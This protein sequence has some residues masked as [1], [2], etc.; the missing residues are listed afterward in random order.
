MD[1]HEPRNILDRAGTIHHCVSVGQPDNGRYP[2]SESGAMRKIF[3]IFM[4]LLLWPLLGRA[5]T[6]TEISSSFPSGT[7][8][9]GTYT[10]ANAVPSQMIGQQPVWYNALDQKMMAFWPD[11]IC[12]NCEW[13]N[14]L[15]EY[16]PATNTFSLAWDGLNWQVNGNGAAALNCSGCSISRTSGVSTVVLSSAEA[17]NLAVGDSFLI[18]GISDST[19]NGQ[20]QVASV[21]GCNSLGNLCTTFTYTQTGQPDSSPGA[22]SGSALAICPA[23]R[24]A[25][26]ERRHSQGMVYD[27]TRNAIWMMTGVGDV[28]ANAT[29]ILFAHSGFEDLYKATYNSP[30]SGHWGW[31]QICGF[32]SSDCGVVNGGVAG[33][34]IPCDPSNSSG[35]GYKFPLIAYDPTNDVIVLFGGNWNSST[36]NETLLYYP[37][38]N[39]WQ[40][41]CPS[42]TSNICN[43][44]TPP[45]RWA[46]GDS[47]MPAIGNGNILLFGHDSGGG[48]NYSDTWIF[49]TTSKTWT[50]V[51]S[52]LVPPATLNPIMDYD[53]VINKVILIDDA[54]SPAHTWF[55]DPTT[56]Q[57][58]DAGYT[59]GPTISTSPGYQSTGAYDA[60][61]N[62]FVVFNGSSGNPTQ[63]WA[64]SLPTSL[65]G[66]SPTADLSP[67]SLTFST[68]TIG[69]TSSSQTVTLT[70]SGTAALT[71]SSISI[72]GSNS[73][74]FA[75]S[76]NCPVS[77]STLSVGASCTISVT[78]TPTLTTTE[79][80][81]LNVSDN[82]AGT[83][84]SLPLTGTG[85]TSTSGGG[86][87]GGSG[88][89]QAV[90][91]PI[92]V[93]AATWNGAPTAS[94]A[95]SNAPVTLG[96]P[97]PDSA[98]VTCSPT[99][100]PLG[101][102]STTAQLELQNGS[103]T[104]QNAQFRCLGLWPDGNAEWVLV[105]GQ[106]P[107][108]TDGTEDTSLNLVQ[109]G[110]GG[111]NNP[112]TSMAVQC[113]GSGTPVSGC[114]DSNHIL[115][116]TTAATFLVKEA[117][118]NLFDSVVVGSTTLVSSG[119]HG[120][121]D[122]LIL[123]GPV[124]PTAGGPARTGID[125]ASCNPGPPPT[126]YSGTSACS[127]GTAGSVY[128]SNLDSTSTCS[129]QD[130][131]PLRSVVMCQGD[132]KNSSGDV[133]M[134]W[135]TYTTF[136]A[137]HSDVK[138]SVGLRNADS[139]TAQNFTSA[140]KEY[141]SLTAQL[142]MNLASGSRTVTFAGA[143]SNT[144]ENLTGGSGDDAY[145][146]QGFSNQYGWP[147]FRASDCTAEGDRCVVSPI[148][149]VETA[150]SAPWCQEGSTGIYYA[151]CG[152]QIVKNGAVAASAAYNSYPVGWADEVD[153]SSNGVEIGEYQFSANWPA[154]LEFASGGNELR[155]GIQPD[156]TLMV[157]SPVNNYAYVQRWPA[158]SIRD[159][160]FN[161]H[162]ST[163]AAPAD[164][165]VEFQQS[166]LGRLPV[167]A[168]NAA[169]NSTTGDLAMM[170][171]LVD[172]VA[173]DTYFESITFS[174]CSSPTAAGSCLG[175]LTPPVIK[176]YGWTN[177]GLNQSDYAWSAL[178]S[179]LERGCTP[180]SGICG[181]L[182]TTGSTPG[183][184][185][186]GQNF[187]RMV[188]EGSIPLSDFAGGWRG[189][190]SSPAT[191]SS[192]LSAWG[193]PDKF[194]SWNGGMRAWEDE[195][196]G[197]DHL[198]TAGL[199]DYY[200][201]SG[202][203]WTYNMLTTGYED[204][205]LNANIA[206]NNP[207]AFGGVQQF[208]VD[209]AAGHWL[210][211]LGRES[212]FLCAIRSASCDTVATPTALVGAEATAAY[213]M[214]A[215]VLASGYPA[216]WTNPSNCGN[217]SAACTSGTSPV[218]GFNAESPNY[219]NSNST[220]NCGSS[221][222]TAP[223][224]GNEH[225]V[226][227]PFMQAVAEEGLY[228]FNAAERAV[229]GTGWSVSETVINDGGQ[230]NVP[231]TLSDGGTQQLAYG[232]GDASLKESFST[233]AGA[234]S[235]F[236]YANY[237]QYLNSTPPCILGSV[238]GGD[239]CSHTCS[240]GC[241]YYDGYVFN[242]FSVG[243]AIDS[244]NDA[245][246]SSWQP[247]FEAY[248]GTVGSGDWTDVGAPNTELD[249]TVSFILTQ[250]SNPGGV[251]ALTDVPI[252]VSPSPCVG[253]AT[254]TITWTVPSGVSTQHG[255]KYR[256]VYY[257]CPT[258]GTDCPSGGK[259]IVSWL[260]FHSNCL[261]SST[262][263]ECTNGTGSLANNVCSGG[264][265]AVDGSGCWEAGKTP[266]THANWFYASVATGSALQNATG[267]YSFTATAGTTYTFNLKA[268]EGGASSSGTGGGSS[269]PAVSLSPTS[270]S[271]PSQ[272]DGTTSA[273]QSIT[274]TNTGNA[275]LTINSIGTTG[276]NGT[277][278][279]EAS[280]CPISPA[281]LAAGTNCAVSVTF[282]PSITGTETAAL[283]ISDNATGS[284]QSVTLAGTG[285]TSSS[286]S[287]PPS[288][289]T[290]GGAAL[291]SNTQF[292]LEPEDLASALSSCVGCQ[293]QSAS[294]L[295]PGQQVEVTLES[296]AST[297]TA[298]AVI[299]RLGTLNGTVATVA[300]NQFTIQ[301]V[302]G[303]AGP[304]SVLVLAPSGITTYQGF[305]SSSGPAQVGQV[306]AVRGLLFKSGPQGGPTLLAERVVLGP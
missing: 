200:F 240:S 154:A 130:N 192:L 229:R 165:F 176:F 301:L 58:S 257:S 26:P 275:A 239:N 24:A 28:D 77:P 3:L 166:L 215:P 291:T 281:T 119:G 53:P 274:L 271:F 216:G 211:T 235:G 148:K 278:F 219:P 196:N 32:G 17:R 267:S 305:S 299:L 109:V 246:G 136:W 80:A 16:D 189:I 178:R 193:Y 270:L 222:G 252:T 124:G 66:G 233:N 22:Q 60:N 175:N 90:K 42:P 255:E 169:M 199:V 191:C 78:F 228:F 49:N 207:A 263:A 153:A 293:F 127:S 149:R 253:P 9:T 108:F 5:Q 19:F 217:G 11:I 162:V 27:T 184:F 23:D 123:V 277:D 224:D 212:L 40:S 218:R 133:Y 85:A 121:N 262:S 147:D 197:E 190:C 230:A 111:G 129:I 34:G 266:D 146:Y 144:S 75:Q 248:V 297:P 86:G 280:T 61:T 115:V 41:I 142:T 2:T 177:G 213:S 1:Q 245:S 238:A 132:L 232:I 300:T 261:T 156:Q 182:A 234:Q 294:D 298:A 81:A 38:T 231:V 137:N 55:F 15:F 72:T 140:Y 206:Y 70:S 155:I 171:P 83:P 93:Q 282:K 118:Y 46:Q 117:N 179:F 210:E 64:L 96:V 7:T 187:Y 4:T 101:Y 88:G 180:S 37:V 285:A 92:G 265:N 195:S 69:T 205:A 135:R 150:Q 143:T 152:Y 279:A 181:A 260:G 163:L 167:S 259:Q 63:I 10:P 306:V 138:L 247:A 105:D 67:S 14:A 57:W 158:Y 73:G 50:Q 91:I 107:S 54:Q 273:P 183:R 164:P 185:V 209:R 103:G 31:T 237:P 295:L 223:C 256:L 112:A 296:G 249:A 160:Y 71:I 44:T 151:Q 8:I 35:C 264:M 174:G 30:V 56:N 303:S 102:G 203:P 283:S 225:W 236:T 125:S 221:G 251:A 97:L 250:R 241:N 13:G 45:V 12:S 220:D 290:V 145:I 268:W 20:F 106:L 170:L 33:N 98:G 36:R 39:T 243:A 122:G 284:P 254:C 68:Q 18:Q 126:N 258:G 172:P 100:N 272:T 159:L 173:E 95:R 286:S 25:N 52:T 227:K 51:N 288:P 198:H 104:V 131:G 186:W 59:G 6:W 84:Q 204:I 87:G 304:S 29:Q 62:Q 168:Y 116:N 128:L 161:F 276:A 47:R 201:L 269:T 82:A 76:D 194:N 302:K 134:H 43:G 141:T 157:Q 208:G 242:F 48:T 289:G 139:S 99:G 287:T 79:S 74:D 120:A 292:S 114:P 226:F 244:T 188:S 202:D 110:S 113:T 89:G 214:A 65:T 94:A 21:S